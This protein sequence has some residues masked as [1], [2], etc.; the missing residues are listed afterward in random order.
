MINPVSNVAVSLNSAGTWTVKMKLP[1]PLATVSP[2]TVA[3]VSTGGIV[4]FIRIIPPPRKSKTRP[5]ET[6]ITF[7]IPGLTGNPPSVF[8]TTNTDPRL[9]GDDKPC[10]AEFL[11]SS[12]CSGVYRRW[13]PKV[14]CG[15]TRPASSHLRRVFVEM[16]RIRA[17]S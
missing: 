2:R 13:L 4:C 9:R 10:E 7:V 16:P 1:D 14:R 11:S 8:F 3:G 5:R 12:I 17:A 15:M 6:R